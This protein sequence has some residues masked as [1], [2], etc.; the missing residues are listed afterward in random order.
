MAS[1]PRFSTIVATASEEAI[2]WCDITNH[3]GP[4][5]KKVKTIFED[6]VHCTISCNVVPWDFGHPG[7]SVTNLRD[8]NFKRYLRGST[9]IQS[10]SESVET[11][12]ILFST[13]SLIS[14]FVVPI[15]RRLD[16]LFRVASSQAFRTTSRISSVLKTKRP[17]I[18]TR[19]PSVRFFRASRSPCCS[20]VSFRRSATSEYAFSRA[21][22]VREIY[23]FTGLSSVVFL[24]TA[25]FGAAFASRRFVPSGG[26][27]LRRER[28]S[29]LGKLR[30][31]SA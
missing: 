10:D 30:V 17:S 26:E 20:V 15:R 7:I 4:P 18:A 3:C 23:R 24:Y 22:V 21:K 2:V 27:L 14:I 25:L 29:A 8:S 31:Y 16:G 12:P 13:S 9:T 1:T 19:F 11:F 28:L 6:R 5:S